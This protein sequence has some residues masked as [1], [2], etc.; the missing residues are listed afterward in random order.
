MIV[1]II[2]GL[3]ALAAVA[4]VRSL[5]RRS[6]HKAART[7]PTMTVRNGYTGLENPI[8][9]VVIERGGPAD[10]A[11]FRWSRDRS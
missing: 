3:I 5:R 7:L 6:R 8:Y 9:R 10:D 1:R 11:T 2:A 4:T